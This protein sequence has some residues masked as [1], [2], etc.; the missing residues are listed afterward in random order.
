M[1][2][3]G[4]VFLALMGTV[5]AI[6]VFWGI[7]S[8]PMTASRASQVLPLDNSGVRAPV[9]AATRRGCRQNRFHLLG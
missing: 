6:L 4:L 9:D 3:G 2:G 1:L 7:S 8:A 5:Q